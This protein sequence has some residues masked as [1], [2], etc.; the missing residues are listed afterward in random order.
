MYELGINNWEVLELDKDRAKKIACKYNLPAL[1]AMLFDIRGITESSEIESFLSEEYEI[2][3]PFEFVDMHSAVSRIR[4]AID[5]FEKICIYGDYDA[6]GV[7]ST[8]LLYLYLENCCANVMYYI[9]DRVNEGY[10]LNINAIDKLLEEGVSLII[11][12]DNG[13]SAKD[14]IKY[15]KSLGIDTVV[16]D[17]HQPPEIL[18][19]A[20]AVVDP[21]R[22]DCGSKFKELA[23][24]GVAFKLVCA[25]EDN[26]D[27]NFLLENYSELLLIGTIGDIVPLKGENR[28]FVKQGLKYISQTENIGIK[29]LL[30]AL[31]LYNHKISST[32][33]A[34]NI[35]P[36]VNAPGRLSNANKIVKLLISDDERESELIARDIYDE[37]EERKK[38]EFD[39]FSQA[40]EILAEEPDR[41]F[42]KVIIVE[43]R[44]WNEGVIGIVASKLLKKYGKPVIVI[45]IGEKTSKAS[46]RSIEG[47]SLYDL[48]ENSKEYLIR[49]GGHQLAAGFEILNENIYRLRND[50]YKF[51]EKFLDMPMPKLKIDCKLNP[52]ALSTDIIRQLEPLEPFGKDNPSILFGL[53]S[54]RLSNIN[55]VGGKKHL[56]LTFEKNGQKIDVMRFYTTTEE[57]PYVIGD[58]LDLAVTIGIS[59]YNNKESLSVILNDLKLS[60]IENKELIEGR[61]IYERIKRNEDL[62]TNILKDIIP[63]RNDFSAVYRFLKGNENKRLNFAILYHSLKGYNIT[64]CKLLII[65]DAMEDCGLILIY[66]DLDFY[67]FTL[68]KVNKKVDL[69]AS[70]IMKSLNGRSGEIE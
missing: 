13:I 31:N 56:K 29:S 20:V 52:A 22:R 37:N 70:E 19:E 67:K 15:A 68:N 1:L 66:T 17:H 41:I 39:M 36:R 32:D 4:E 47:F 24:V 57:F 55:A 18:P 35:V 25:L 46:G 50:M 3:D 61:C 62:D 8:A 51:C 9:P 23:G 53:Y 16:T 33:I 69:Q 30:L 48:V 42:Q 10:G 59:F 64:P 14:E 2:S 28:Y 40:E 38:I 34:F 65:L 5:N 45:S 6:D 49:F 58:K 11:T 60:E 27:I 21:H 43:G 54:M 26:L 7:T 63:T 44:G 12:V